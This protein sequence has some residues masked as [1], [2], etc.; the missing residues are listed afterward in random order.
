[1]KE[2]TGDDPFADEG[3]NQEELTMGESTTVGLEDSG[4]SGVPPLAM[5]RDGVKGERDMVPVWMQDDTEVRQKEVKQEVE[6]ILGYDVY[7]TDFK[8]AAYLEGLSNPEGI[9][10]KLEEWGCEYA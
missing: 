8:E 4:T 1:M 3:D 10:E 6:E 5:R 9:A 2:G 7:L